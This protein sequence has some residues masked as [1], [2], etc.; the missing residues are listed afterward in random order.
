MYFTAIINSIIINPRPN[1]LS[2]KSIVIKHINIVSIDIETN[3]TL[4]LSFHHL[5]NPIFH[6]LIKILSYYPT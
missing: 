3:S 4:F 1:K 6:N 5:T 2:I